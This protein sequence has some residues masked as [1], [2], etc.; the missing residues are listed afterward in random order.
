MTP[1]I[2]I[3][4][5]YY[6][7]PEYLQPCICSLVEQVLRP[8]Q[9][10]IVDDGS[11][12]FPISHDV[13]ARFSSIPVCLLTLVNSGVA[14]ARN[15]GISELS[16]SLVVTLDADDLLAPD[17]LAMLSSALIESGKSI[18]YSDIETFGIE[19]QVFRHPPYCYERLKRG[20]YMVNAS[21]MTREVWN[22]VRRANG[23]GYDTRLDRLGGYEDH[24]FWLEAGALGYEAVH[25]DR[26]LFRYRRHASSKLVAARR[27][28]PELRVY[29]K[30]KMERLYGIEL[31]SLSVPGEP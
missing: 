6:E 11:R 4:L 8:D 20:N 1:S 2:G 31:P 9:V 21:M 17:Y 24:L 19:E 12:R 16:T 25:V 7:Q 23:E 10:V 26:I 27:V 5:C 29:M 14:N 30:Q 15:R 3:V 22:A 18:A 13:H 28:F